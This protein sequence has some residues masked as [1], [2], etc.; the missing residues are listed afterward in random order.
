MKYTVTVLEGGKK[1]SISSGGNKL[2]R[3]NCSSVISFLASKFET[4][5]RSQCHPKMAVSVLYGHGYSN[6]TLEEDLND[7]QVQKKLLF[8]ISCFLEDYLEPKIVKECEDD[9]LAG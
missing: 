2:I 4:T 8:T 7:L 3:V 6:D 9:Y 1:F 5:L